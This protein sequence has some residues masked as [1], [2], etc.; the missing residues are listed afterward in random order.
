MHRRRETS[1]QTAP[2]QGCVSLK[3]G[4]LGLSTQET[5]IPAQ[6]SA[7][8]SRLAAG[9]ALAKARKGSKDP[10]PAGSEEGRQGEARPYKCLR[11][12]EGRP[13]S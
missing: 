3:A 6:E 10:N 4:Q 12:R 9:E 1:P 7:T 8:Q 2:L 11:G 13:R 5:H